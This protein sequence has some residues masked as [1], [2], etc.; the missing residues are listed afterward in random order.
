MSRAHTF[1]NRI[2]AIVGR[3]NV[4][5]SRLFNRLA[6]RRISIVHDEAG[7]TRDVISTEIAEGAYTLLDTSGLG[8]TG[9]DT[10]QR[11]TA[12]A[13]QQVDFAIDTA[14][15][16]LF[17]IDGLSGTTA[18]DEQIARRLRRAKARV[19]LVVNKADF[20]EARV[21]MAE[22]YRFGLGEPIAVSAEHGHGEAQLRDAIL[23]A[24]GPPPPEPSEDDE[25]E[26]ALDDEWEDEDAGEGANVA[27]AWEA[28]EQDAAGEDSEAHGEGDRVEGHAVSNAR[29]RVSR[30]K[31]EPRPLRLCF[32]GRPNV[33]KSSLS[34]R[35]LA[36]DRLIV[37]DVPGTTRDAVELPF[38]F[39]GRDGR[40]YP[41]SLIDTAGIKAA[42]KLAAPVEYFSRLRSLD[43][44]A[45]AD[46]VFLVLDALEGVT[47]QDKAIAGEAVKERKPIVVVVNKWDLVHAAFET[48]EGLKGFASERDYREKYERA[49]FER[50][51]FTPG[52]PL[53]FASSHS[54]FALDR[55]MNAAVKLDRTLEKKLPT[56]RLNRLL[57][58]L[59]ER[60]P[61]PLVGS[62]RFRIYYATQTGHRPFRIR[63]FCNRE[64][65]LPESYRRYL[66]AGVI[67][68]FKLEGCPVYFDLVG[69]EKHTPGTSYTTSKKGAGA[70]QG[71]G[72]HAAA[73]HA[74]WRHAE[75]S[76][77]VGGSD[78]DGDFATLED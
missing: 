76:E 33:G 2:V 67:R 20:D 36:S 26:E 69:K 60:T 54:D 32:L 5:K 14:G 61:P 62:R 17:V 8:L 65:R 78:F 47:Q 4:G 64:D 30:K 49:V 43:A 46:V 45:R 55:M 13:E 12:A 73:P 24:L 37:S 74:K 70:A 11:I 66:E 58:E 42:T 39:T 10:P 3:P 28:G 31:K 16:I 7:I 19:R 72:A 44:I 52:A 27:A 22:A 63:I 53:I 56:G 38:T 1:N 57:A 6:R 9:S 25:N 18:L 40:S 59:T 23:E 29:Q 34:N 41:F 35:L 51:F 68:E 21:D 77:A 71:R 50:L 75:A 48:P 15:L